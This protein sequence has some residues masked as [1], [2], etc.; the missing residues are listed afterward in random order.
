MMNNN[1]SFIRKN[2]NVPLHA[3]AQKKTIV[4]PQLYPF[5]FTFFIKIAKIKK[6]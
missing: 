4:V 6:F 5:T 3:C 1:M 2:K